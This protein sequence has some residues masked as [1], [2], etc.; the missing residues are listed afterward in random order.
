[1]AGD[2]GRGNG[3]NPI[4]TIRSIRFV[5]VVPPGR[6]RGSDR[7]LDRE[8]PSIEDYVLVLVV[9]GRLLHHDG[10]SEGGGRLRLPGRRRPLRTVDF[11]LFWILGGEG[12]EGREREGGGGGGRKM[13]GEG[14]KNHLTTR[15]RGGLWCGRQGGGAGVT[16]SGLKYDLIESTNPI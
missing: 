9:G 15:G 5:H 13:K 14:R 4:C 3:D 11:G 6:G 2:L 7:R 16:L 8:E 1:M 10:D 12:G